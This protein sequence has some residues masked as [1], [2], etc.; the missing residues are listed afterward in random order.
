MGYINILEDCVHSI[1]GIKDFYIATMDVSGNT[2]SFPIDAI[3]ET[4][5]TPR[6]VIGSIDKENEILNLNNTLIKYKHIIPDFAS[7]DEEETSDRQGYTFV[8]RLQWSMPQI[9]NYTNNELKEFLFK[10]DGKFAI[11]NALVFFKDNNDQWW[12]AGF[13]IPFI[14]DTF[15]INL[16][17]NDSYLLKYTSKS[18]LRTF[19]LDL[20]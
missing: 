20:S 7:Y 9:N 11:S 15:D 19:K 1:G 18:Y 13:D 17:D 8:K 5:V 4:S 12:I 14:L 6:I 10:T 3:L 2:L 16:K